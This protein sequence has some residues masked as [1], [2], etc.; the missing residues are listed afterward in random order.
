MACANRHTQKEDGVWRL[1]QACIVGVMT[2]TD[3][4]VTWHT[5]CLSC[6][7]YSDP[8]P[9]KI[10]S[11]WGK[12]KFDV[13]MLARSI[14]G[15][16]E[17]IMAEGWYTFK[18]TAVEPVTVKA[19]TKNHGKPMYKTTFMVT[20]GNY[21]GRT[22]DKWICLFDGAWFTYDKVCKSLSL[23][24]DHDAV[25]N[26][27]ELLNKTLRASVKHE[28]GFKDSGMVAALDSF[29]SVE[30]DLARRGKIRIAI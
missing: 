23:P 9:V 26:A 1:G 22:L 15:F 12:P 16:D 7:V 27:S 8:I 5:K 2:D 29:T 13:S 11:K 20:E 14:I 3:E 18:I 17:K 6:G 28:P 10:A 30:A 25:V 24:V 19:Q 4:N 21:V